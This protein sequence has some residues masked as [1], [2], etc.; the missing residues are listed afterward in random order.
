VNYEL[1]DEQELLR[2]TVRVFALTRV[3]PVAAE[4]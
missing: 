1:T 4:L 2:P 3:A